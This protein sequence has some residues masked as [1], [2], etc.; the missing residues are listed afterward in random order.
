[1]ITKLARSKEE[2][3]STNAQSAADWNRVKV[4]GGQL[5]DSSALLRQCQAK[6]IAVLVL[7]QAE[8]YFLL[9]LRNGGDRYDQGWRPENNRKVDDIKEVSKVGQKYK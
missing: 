3:V 6:D 9:S 7:Q 1:V 5:G 4:R 2:T 8:E